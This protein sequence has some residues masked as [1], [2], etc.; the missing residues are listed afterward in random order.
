ME[1]NQFDS[2]LVLSRYPVSS[3]VDLEDEGDKKIP[4]P[5]GVEL[6]TFIQS[7]GYDSRPKPSLHVASPIQQNRHRE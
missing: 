7:N 6:C 2:P 5:D 4:V 1:V 3:R